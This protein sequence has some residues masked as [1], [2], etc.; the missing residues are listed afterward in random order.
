MKK[1]LVNII[2]FAI[3]FTG[4]AQFTHAEEQAVSLEA[5]VHGLSELTIVMEGA[6]LEIQ[7]TSPAMNLLGFEH[8]ASSAKDIAT[9]KNAASLLGKHDAHFLLSEK[10]CDHVK[11]SIDLAELIESNDHEHAHEK[12]SNEHKHDHDD[13]DHNNHHSEIVANYKYH[14]E[15]KSSLSVMTVALFD[16]FPGIHKIQTMWIKQT[17][18]GATTLTPNNRIIEFR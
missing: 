9:V 1:H 13:H 7:L 2:A 16:S 3:T 6:S 14:C 12:K 18:Q 17:Q 5:H 4:I 10:S 8:R 15:N 11:T